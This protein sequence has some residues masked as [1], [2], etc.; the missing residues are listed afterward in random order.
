D[1]VLVSDGWFEIKPGRTLDYVTGD[2]HHRYYYFYAYSKRDEW[3]GNHE[4]WIHPTNNFEIAHVREIKLPKG[5]QK[6]GF[7]R[8]D[9]GDSRNH[10]VNL[11][12]PGASIID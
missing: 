7:K 6:V 1:G 3:N 11:L 8:I 9:T 12:A 2:L 4:F 5:A 10:T